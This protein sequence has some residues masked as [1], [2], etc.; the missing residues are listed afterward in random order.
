MVCEMLRVFENS[1]LA[2]KVATTLDSNGDPLFLVK[3]VAFSLGYS[4]TD[5]AIRTHVS[6]KYKTEYR[7]LNPTE[8]PSRKIHP[9]TLFVRE[10]GL[11][12]LLFSSHLPLARVFREWVMEEVLPSIRKTGRYELEDP[13]QKVL[14]IG[15]D[16]LATYDKERK[17]YKTI[18]LSHYELLKDKKKQERGKNGG[19]TTQERIRELKRENVELREKCDACICAS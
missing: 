10:P 18:I 4:D 19:H 11:Y 17:E 2:A 15:I 3:D 8:S 6:E 1:V 5:R 9:S 14:S 13:I 7:N 16:E 12:E